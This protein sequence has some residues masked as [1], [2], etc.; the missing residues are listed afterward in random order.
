M[1]GNNLIAVL[2]ALV[3]GILLGNLPGVPVWL[4]ALPA[5]MGVVFFIVSAVLSRI[6]PLSL[7]GNWNLAVALSLFMA[8]GMFS[9]S[10]KRPSPDPATLTDGEYR[11][12][13]TVEDC[14]TTTSGDRLIVAVSSLEKQGV[15]ENFQNLDPRNLKIQVTLQDAS[16]TPEYGSTISGKMALQRV[17]K[18]GNVIRD[19]YIYYLKNKRIFLTGYAL[20]G[21]YAV[22]KPQ[23]GVFTFFKS[24]RDDLEIALEHTGLDRP[25][26]EFLISFLLGD[27]TYMREE[28]RLNFTDAGVA[29]IFA[30]SGF[31]VSLVGGIILALLSLVFT[32]HLRRWRFMLALPFVWF[33]ILLVGAS[34]ATCRAG[35]MLSIGFSALFL[36]RKNNSLR[37]LGWAV[38]LILCFCPDALFDI[39]FQLSV[40]CVG[41]LLLI[42]SPL[43][44]VR[45]REH[46]V[47]YRVVGLTLV[48]LTASFSVWILTGYYFHRFSLMFLPLN[49]VAVP[50]LPVF[51]VVA[52]VYLVLA[53]LGIDATF[54]ARIL[55]SSFRVFSDSAA[56]LTSASHT[57]DHFYPSA[58]SVV[59][60]LAGLTALGIVLARSRRR[61]LLC[62]P[63]GIFTLSLVSLPLLSSRGLPDGFIIQKN[64]DTASLAVYRD[65]MEEIVSLPRGIHSEMDVGGQK[66]L[67]LV[68]HD[69][70]ETTISRLRD[71]DIILLCQGC[72]ELPG[73]ISDYMKDGARV[74]THPSIH[75]RLERNILSEAA[76]AGIS[77]HSLRYDGPLHQFS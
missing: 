29:H 48:A 2:A 17:D 40:V 53:F 7:N 14:R 36:Q 68:S 18:P 12:S 6:N 10:L 19:D 23:A 26:K 22:G 8:V 59:L 62:I 35:I 43:N 70:S 37:S 16:E 27:K 51:I 64:H 61:K 46:P 33:Y 21:N 49:L 60:W 77:I 45:H 58:V 30:V 54:L 42:A 52:L 65:G 76:E 28:D 56:T 55:D 66:I 15:G 34:P 3:A 72:R 63:L 9:A 57:F 67:A 71:A 5:A 31:H 1:R 47:L 44:F 75:W 38:V 11:F 50:L 39:G 74:V 24:L 20:P 69:L 73:N 41:S 25:T 13:G 32:G 4:A